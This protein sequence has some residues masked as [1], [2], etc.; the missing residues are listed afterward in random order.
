MAL[1]LLALPA[2]AEGFEAGQA[3]LLGGFAGRLEVVA[4]VELA[5]VLEQVAA[6]GA[7][8][9]Q[10]DVGVDVDLAHAVL[11]ALDDFLD[12]H[13]VGFLHVAAEF[14]DLGE[15]F[16]RHRRRAVHDQVGV[17][18]AG[19]DFL[20]A[21]DGE[22]VAG[23]LLGEL[24]GAVAGADGDG[25]R[26][27]VGLLD[28][29]GGLLDVGQQLFAGHVAFGAVAV[30]LVA[31]HGFERAEHAEFGFDGNADGVREFDHLLRVTATLY[32]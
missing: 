19:V 27:A 28:E 2:A 13:A 26:V 15:Q 17:R 32:S 22:D 9:R 25:Q 5:R 4:R 21:V 24:V 10:A 12:R 16:L 18:D 8:H 14:A 23:R 20:D 31:L 11:D 7:G 6:D 1:I 3:D 29:V 30:F